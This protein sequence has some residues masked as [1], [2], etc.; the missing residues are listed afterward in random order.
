MKI[1]LVNGPN[2]NLLGQREPEVYGSVTLA[3]IEARVRE[4]AAGLNAEVLSFQSNHEGAIVDFLQEQASEADGLIING[5]ALTH[6]GLSLRD[7]IAASGLPAIEV[8][9]SNIYGRES[10]RRRSV[11]AAVCRGMVTG[12]GWQGYLAALDALV[13]MLRE[14]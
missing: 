13:Q 3:D 14:E 10:F 4:H 7:A 5:G 2:L 6:Y 11:T 1:L 9:I 12:L 8:H